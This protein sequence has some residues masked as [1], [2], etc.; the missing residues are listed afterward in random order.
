MTIQ[1]ETTTS[2]FAGLE[3]L[4]GGMMFTS[5]PQVPVTFECQINDIFKRLQKTSDNTICKTR[6]KTTNIDLI[7]NFSIP[8]NSTFQFNYCTHAIVTCS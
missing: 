6:N 7:T 1:I 2:H 5:K 3:G 8:T 4:S